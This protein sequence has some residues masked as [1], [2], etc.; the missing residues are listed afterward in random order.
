[1]R[2]QTSLNFLVGVALVVGGFACKSSKE[3]A[4]KVSESDVRRLE[5]YVFSGDEFQRVSSKVEFKFVPKEGV[6]AGMKGMVKIRRDSCLVLSFQPFAGI[7]AARCLIRK[8][9]MFIMSRFHQTYAVEELTHLKAARYLNLELLQAVLLNKVFMP[10]RSQSH[11][12]DL[13]RFEWHKQKEGSYF[14]WPDEDF[15]LDFCID[16]EGRYSCLRAS[17][18]E[19]KEKINVQYGLF[20]KKGTK[21]G[22]ETDFPKQVLLS[23]E[24]PERNMKLQITYLKP[25]F[26]DSEDFRFEI[27]LKYKKVTPEEWIKRFQ[28]ML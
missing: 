17:C 10:G 20:D 27:P 15:I 26:D 22:M 7:E 25:D 11:L 5:Q 9:S 4:R 16:E 13:S 23:L 21:K 6:S 3:V 24:S 12:A 2:K 1:M 8:D 14:R 19:K 18:P 28:G